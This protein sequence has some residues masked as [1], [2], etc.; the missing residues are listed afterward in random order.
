MVVDRDESGDEEDLPLSLKMVKPRKRPA[1][2]QDEP[3]EPVGVGAKKTEGTDPTTTR[4]PMTPAPPPKSP[5]DAPASAHPRDELGA[6]S[7]CFVGAPCVGWLHGAG[8][9]D[10]LLRVL[11]P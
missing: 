1:K 9:D 8:D 6:E 2:K 11:R 7:R 4:R 10:I 5:G 3:K